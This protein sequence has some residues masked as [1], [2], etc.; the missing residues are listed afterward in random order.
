MKGE[1]CSQRTGG[2]RGMRTNKLFYSYPSAVYTKNTTRPTHTLT[3]QM[4]AK[5][6]TSHEHRHRHEGGAV[7]RGE[8]IPSVYSVGDRKRVDMKVTGSHRSSKYGIMVLTGT[9]PSGKRMSTFRKA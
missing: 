2:R 9:S 3:N 7:S 5:K 8:T 1:L 4:R 6:A